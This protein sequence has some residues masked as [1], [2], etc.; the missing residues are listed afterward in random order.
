MTK[1]ARI[2]SG[3]NT[4]FFKVSNHEEKGGGAVKMIG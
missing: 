1:V 3:E 2:H 4:V